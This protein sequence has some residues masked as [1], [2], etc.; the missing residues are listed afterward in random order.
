[1]NY[2]SRPLSLS[3]NLKN[4]RMSAL[5]SSYHHQAPLHNHGNPLFF[6]SRKTDPPSLPYLPFSVFFARLAL[7]SVR[8]LPDEQRRRGSYLPKVVS[9]PGRAGVRFVVPRL[10]SLR[11]SSRSPVS[12]RS[13]FYLVV[14][15]TA[16]NAFLQRRRRQLKS[17]WRGIKHGPVSDG[18]NV[19]LVIHY[20]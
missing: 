7:P 8:P 4:W 15:Y 10:I 2:I 6:P 5:S 9:T 12:E 19:F 1:M 20:S 17:N 13:R 18:T 11:P 14:I 3:I 16:K